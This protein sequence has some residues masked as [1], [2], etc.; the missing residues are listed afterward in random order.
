MRILV[1]DDHALLA[2][3]LASRLRTRGHEVRVEVTPEDAVAAA[4]ADQPDLCLM[5]LRFPGRP[6]GGLQAIP[7]LRTESPETAV[8]L[9]SA[10]ADAKTARAA[11]TAGAHGVAGKD[12]A[13]PALERAVE[14]IAL[15]R[16]V[17]SEEL[18]AG[19]GRASLTDR[20]R[21]VIDLV[22]AGRSTA[23]IATD[24]TISAATVRGHVEA[25]LGKLGVHSRLH[26][27]TLAG[28]RVPQ[29]R[30]DTT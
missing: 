18:T 8:L 9:L 5:D 25:I 26:A 23:Q 10:A 24:L 27:A 28:R 11:L 12:I 3:A 6:L 29:Q 21:Q 17:A 16:V 19:S 2:E 14:Q 15:G 22:A 20:E 13:L 1:C 30:V 7:D 4:A